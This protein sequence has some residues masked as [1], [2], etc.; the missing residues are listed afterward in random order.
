MRA[1]MP[2]ARWPA[3]LLAWLGMALVVWAQSDVTPLVP[4]SAPPT[5]ISSK[6]ESDPS[7]E[8][9]APDASGLDTNRSVPAPILVPLPSAGPP[10]AQ[11]PPVTLGGLAPQRWPLMHW[12]QGTWAGAGLDDQRMQVYGWTQ[13]NFTASTDRDSNL[14]LGM[15]Y[16]ANQFL[17]EQNWLRIDR[18]V[19]NKGTSEPT[20]GFRSDWIL[21]GSDYFFTLP[22]GLFNSQ[23]TA[24]HGQPNLYGIDP[25]QFFVEAYFPTVA[26]GMD[27]K[28]GRFFTQFGV[29]QIS[30]PDNALVSHAYTFIYNPFTQ[31]GILTTTK[32]N[33]SVSVQAGLVVGNDN[34]SGAT[35]NPTFIGSIKWVRFDQRDSLLFNVIADKGRFDQK[36]N[37]HNPEILDLV[38]THKINTNLLY[39]FEGL[40]GFTNNVPDIGTAN[41]MSIIHYL[42]YNFTEQV[43]GATRL[44]F[45]DDFQGQRTG[46]KGLYTAL[47]AMLAYRPVKWLQLRQELRYDYHSDT[48]PF[49]GKHGLL[50]ATSDFILRW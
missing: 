11:P 21:P 36:N 5:V 20:F 1:T 34:F 32:L 27:V 41:W 17:L 23:L 12:L 40:Y 43:N 16:K 38:A 48:A 29:E 3:S 33:E 10:A 25:V 28:V 35:L 6:A 47:A 24:N 18:T 13:G 2:G 15:N 22:R 45:F 37:F 49:E 42:T 30:A 39:S 4:A 14:P 7:E 8:S 50:T 19:V 44:E 46:F 31:T 9:Q 26:Q